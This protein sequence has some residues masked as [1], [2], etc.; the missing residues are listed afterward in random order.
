MGSSVSLTGE[1]TVET[2][3]TVD[4]SVSPNWRQGALVLA[5]TGDREL[6]C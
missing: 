2:V 1:E 3:E 4:S 6:Q 5:L